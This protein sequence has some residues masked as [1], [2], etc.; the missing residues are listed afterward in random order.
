[1]V[2]DLGSTPITDHGDSGYDFVYYERLLTGPNHIEMDR[3]L[4]EIGDG[5]N[6]Y[7]VFDWGGGGPDTNSNVDTGVIG[8]G[9]GENRNIASGFLINNSGVGIDIY[10]LG[11]IGSY[12]YLRISAP[13]TGANDGIDI[14]AIE[15]YP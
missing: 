7:T 3:V 12:Q 11:L 2:F 13:S 8:G 14:D 1:L 9:E 10:S 4:I 15:I 6:W 5:T